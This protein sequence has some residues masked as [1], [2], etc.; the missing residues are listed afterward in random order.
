MLH[1]SSRPLT[2][3]QAFLHEIY[4]SDLNLVCDMDDVELAW[5]Y[6]KKT[7]FAIIDKH[8]PIRRYKVRGRDNLWFNDYIAT[9]IRERSEAWIKAK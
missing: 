5:S 8:V 2:N 1:I 6:F 9:A 3:E 7:L 4:Q